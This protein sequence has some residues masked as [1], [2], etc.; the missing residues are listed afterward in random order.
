[1]A[2]DI[3]DEFTSR[4]LAEATGVAAKVQS[5][6]AQDAVE[7]CGYCGQFFGP[8]FVAVE[9]HIHGRKLRFCDENCYAEF[10][11]KTDFRDQDLDGERERGAHIDL[12][13]DG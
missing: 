11:E 1:M 12:P 4:R 3:A 9:R 7:A 13:D 5:H 8:E 6:L 2:D 10:N